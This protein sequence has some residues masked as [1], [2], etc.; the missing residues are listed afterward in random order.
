MDRIYKQITLES[1]KS[2]IPGSLSVVG[3]ETKQD[4]CVHYVSGD[5][6]YGKLISDIEIPQEFLSAIIDYTD[7]DSFQFEFSTADNGPEESVRYLC[8]DTEDMWNRE[9]TQEITS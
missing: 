2:R 3:S 5:G 9:D 1:L 7:T 6:N 8:N 4:N